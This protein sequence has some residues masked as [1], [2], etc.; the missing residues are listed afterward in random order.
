MTDKEKT[1]LGTMGVIQV[2]RYISA[3]NWVRR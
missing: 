1:E 3:S 2:N